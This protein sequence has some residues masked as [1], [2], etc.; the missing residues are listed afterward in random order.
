MTQ[1]TEADGACVLNQVFTVGAVDPLAIVAA[2][3][4]VTFAQVTAIITSLVNFYLFPEAG[5]PLGDARCLRVGAVLRLRRSN[6]CWRTHVRLARHSSTAHVA[7][8]G[9]AG[10]D[11]VK[12]VVATGLE[13]PRRRS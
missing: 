6:A 1:Y 12:P 9:G 11:Q 10:G 13:V 2:C 4:P 5:A 7:A 8:C 3:V